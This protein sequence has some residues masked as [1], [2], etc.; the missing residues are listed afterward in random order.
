[1]VKAVKKM[2]RMADAARFIQQHCRTVGKVN[3]G[4]NCCRGCVFSRE[5]KCVLQG[6]PEEWRLRDA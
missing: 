2:N 5:N 3:V 1:M 4:N 6:C